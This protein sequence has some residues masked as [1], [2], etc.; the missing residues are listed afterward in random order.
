MT[1]TFAKDKPP[2]AYRWLTNVTRT[3][4]IA[5]L[6][7]LAAKHTNS[8]VI[9]HDSAG[10]YDDELISSDRC[11]LSKENPRYNAAETND[12]HGSIWSLGH[13][14]LSMF[15]EEF[16]RL[17]KLIT[18]PL[19]EPILHDDY[20]LV[21][22]YLYIANGVPTIFVDGE[23]MTVALWK[24]LRLP[25]GIK[26]VSEVRRYDIIGRRHRFPLPKPP[27]SPINIGFGRVSQGQ[28][29]RK[30]RSSNKIKKVS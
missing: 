19:N 9:Y 5:E 16:R 7:G 29:V 3:P 22:G 17:E 20:P 15:W 24:S 18:E 27:V 12:S 14:D 13:P 8:D 6:V 4:V 2:K 28:K 21:Q 11:E 1:Q 25:G 30:P 10:G 26:P 23:R